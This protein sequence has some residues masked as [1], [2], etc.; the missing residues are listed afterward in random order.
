MRR[1]QRLAERGSAGVEPQQET[2]TPR[3]PRR[4]H[5]TMA[6][7]ADDNAH[8]NPSRP[9]TPPIPV[10]QADEA[11]L[12]FL[13]RLQQYSETTAAELRKWEEEEAAR[14]HEIQHQLAEAEAARLQAAA[15]A[16]TAARLQQQQ[17]EASQN[18]ARYQATMDLDRDEA[19]Y[20][21]LLRRQHFQETE[22][23]EEPTEEERDKEGTTVLMETLLYTCNWQQ[24]E[25][26]AMRQVLIRHETTLKAMDKRIATL[27]TENST[28]HAANSQQQ[29]LNHQ[30]QADVS[31]GL[32]Q[33]SAA[34]STVSAAVDC[35][36]T[37]VV[38]AKQ[39]EERINHLLASLGNISKFAGASTVS[40]CRRSA[41]TLTNDR[42]LP[43]R[44]GRCRTSSSTTITRLIRCN[45]G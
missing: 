1:S 20:A 6:A 14:Q 13:E 26:L 41:T 40:S 12:V 25:L 22:E 11:L 16:A 31:M 29:T 42:P 10:Q 28:L 32:A 19:T 44:N 17:V 23:Q 30:L 38:Q 5:T 9:V 27:Q 3:I 7:T 37:L 43:P 35:S 24:R 4:P 8:A 39:L 2:K 15:E 33:L 45:G 21:M 36:P 34:A 18:Q